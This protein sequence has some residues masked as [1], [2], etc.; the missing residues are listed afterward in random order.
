MQDDKEFEILYRELVADSGPWVVRG[1]P[2]SVDKFLTAQDQSDWP[3]GF[4]G[5]AR[6]QLIHVA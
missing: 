6:Y 1:D 5:W 3:D 4:C 2:E